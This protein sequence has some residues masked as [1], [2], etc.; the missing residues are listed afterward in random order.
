LLAIILLLTTEIGEAAM[1]YLG[2]TEYSS[3]AVYLDIHSIEQSNGGISISALVGDGCYEGEV[4]IECGQ[5]SAVTYLDAWLGGE[6]LREFLQRC[7]QQ[8]L[9]QQL[10]DSASDQLRQ[11]TRPKTI[12]CRSVYPHFSS[13]FRVRIAEVPAIWTALA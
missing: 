11:L 13:N 5:Q 10:L 7:G 9:K 3:Q 1:I 4:L 12:R 8:W 2:T 6:G